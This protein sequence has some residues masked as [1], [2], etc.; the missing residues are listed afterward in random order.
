[1]LTVLRNMRALVARPMWYAQ[2]ATLSADE[3]GNVDLADILCLAAAT[4]GTERETC[5]IGI[6]THRVIEEMP[7][8]DWKSTQ[9]ESLAVIDEL[10]ARL[11]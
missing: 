4:Y 6:A 10:I 1:M 9:Q 11:N 3:D 2:V 8:R 5:E 7:V